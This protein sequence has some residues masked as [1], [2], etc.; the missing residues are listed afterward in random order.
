[1]AAAAA[2]LFGLTVLAW[3]GRRRCPWFLM[4]WAWFAITLGPVIGWIQVGGQSMAD[5]YTYIPLIGV[6]LILAWGLQS[7]VSAAQVGVP[8]VLSRVVA[9]V[10][11]PLALTCAALTYHQAG[12]WRT[13]ESLWSHALA[14]TPN[15]FLA[16][17]NLGLDLERQQRFPEAASEFR[18]AIRL[19]PT[20][21][22][23]HA[24]LANVLCRQERVEEGINEFRE[25]IRLDPRSVG[26]RHNLAFA[27]CRQ[28]RFQEGIVQFEAILKLRPDS[29]QTHLD[30]GV[31][32]A[33]VG[34]ISDAI[35]HL[36]RALELRPGFPEARRQLQVLMKVANP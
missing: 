25:A 14:V 20:E 28:H 9:W 35:T 2:L 10:P 3:V 15:N 18:E 8:R 5:R 17:V 29:A 27:L 6:F 33:D 19:R 31:A 30:L 23:P 34:R 21:A 22:K 4:G 24:N 1:M 12:Y 16:H 7:G 32:L 36:E 11:L 26:A 13:S